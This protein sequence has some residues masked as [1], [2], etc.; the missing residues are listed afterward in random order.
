MVLLYNSEGYFCEGEVGKKWQFEMTY[1]RILLTE[2]ELSFIKKSNIS[3]TEIGSSVDD[4]HKDY[5]IPLSKIKK[6][7]SIK[8]GKIYTVKVETRDNYLFSITLAN[9]KS[10]GKNKSIELSELINDTILNSSKK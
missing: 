5:E 4:F 7:Y 1:G 10:F 6:A 3:L 8:Q 2:L 9:E